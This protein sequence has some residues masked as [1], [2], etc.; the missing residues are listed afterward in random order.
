MNQQQPQCMHDVLIITQQDQ[1]Q[2]IESLMQLNLIPRTQVCDACKR[3]MN[4]N[5]D[6]RIDG[7]AFR[8]PHYLCRKYKSIRNGSL[9]EHCKYDLQ[10]CL[11]LYAAWCDDYTPQQAASLLN[12]SDT[13]GIRRFFSKIRDKAVEWYNNDLEENPL[14]STGGTLQADETALG[15]AKYNRGKALKRHCNWLAGIVDTSTHRMAVEQVS[16]R[17]AKTLTTFIQ[18]SVQP[19]STIHTDQWK[20][21][22]GLT[23]LNYQHHTVNHKKEYVH[24]CEDGTLVHTQNVEAKWRSLKL[25]L[26]HQSAMH[27]SRTG[28]YA[29]AYAARN[30]A[31]NTFPAF[32]QFIKIPQ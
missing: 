20:G 29:Q 8:C 22:D 32:F 11:L 10:T 27:R 4:L 6:D 28:Q 25:S 15:H 17:T 2:F 7:F 24:T 14:G 9:F 5:A 26:H 30:N 18:A 21:Y 23:D 31:G 13:R 3:P 12:I 1:E 16:D 19:N